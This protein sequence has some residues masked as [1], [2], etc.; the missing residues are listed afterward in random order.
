MTAGAWLAGGCQPISVHV[1][2]A[3]VRAVVRPGRRESTP[4]R[5]MRLASLLLGRLTPLR[6][7]RARNDRPQPGRREPLGPCASLVA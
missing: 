3:D 5:T 4:P 1:P 2:L 6:H 7:Q